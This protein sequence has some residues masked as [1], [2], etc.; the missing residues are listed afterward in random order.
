MNDELTPCIATSWNGWGLSTGT[1]TIHSWNDGAAND[2]GVPPIG[3]SYDDKLRYVP[4]FNDYRENAPSARTRRP[5]RSRP[6]RRLFVEEE[7]EDVE[8]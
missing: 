4:E 7:D 3:K 1:C 8:W 6:V 2:E 5:L